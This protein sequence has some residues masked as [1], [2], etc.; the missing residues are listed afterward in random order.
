LIAFQHRFVR[1]S[2]QD[3]NGHQDQARAVGIRSQVVSCDLRA[4]S[5]VYE[6]L[7]I[8]IGF[9]CLLLASNCAP[10]AVCRKFRIK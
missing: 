3:S 8:A 1:V 7:A 2:K 4:D 5:A 6:R 10:L 9:N